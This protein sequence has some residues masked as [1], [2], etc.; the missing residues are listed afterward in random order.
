MWSV[1]LVVLKHSDKHQYVLEPYQKHFRG[2]KNF[3][4][5]GDVRPGVANTILR[6]V[7]KDSDPD[8]QRLVEWLTL[9]KELGNGHYRKGDDELSTTFWH[10]VT[11]QIF[12]LVKTRHW[13]L[14]KAAGGKSFEDQFTAVLFQI[15]NNRLAA[16]IRS[17]KKQAPHERHEN[18]QGAY[19]TF[20]LAGRLNELLGTDWQGDRVQA[21]KYALR[22]AVVTRLTDG[23]KQAALDMID[24]AAQ[25]DPTSRA[26]Q[27]GRQAIVRWI[28]TGIA[29]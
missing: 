29:E 4:I 11:L 10:R 22:V 16:I 6:E 23:D 21:A 8:P 13:P 15:T 5:D 18:E 28:S 12:N 14:V 19:D 24:L 20:Y 25:R 17:M 7:K 9:H 3:Q 26:I 27:Q 1:H 2:F